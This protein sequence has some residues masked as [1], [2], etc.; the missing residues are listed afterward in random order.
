MNKMYRVIY[1]ST[2]TG[3]YINLTVD[4]A[5]EDDAKAKA[6]A[7]LPS[8]DFILNCAYCLEEDWVSEQ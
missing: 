4:A 3:K 5:S 7:L 8:T 1:L 6:L 2:T